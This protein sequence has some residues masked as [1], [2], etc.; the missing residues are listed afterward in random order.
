MGRR[1]NVLQNTGASLILQFVTAISGLI[2]PKLIISAFG[3]EVNGLCASI[4]QFLGYIS[5]LQAG[6]EGV[7]RASLYRPLSNNDIE[8]V[9]GIVNDAKNFYRKIAFVFI[10]YVI[11]LC[12][13][14]PLF[15]ESSFDKVYIS[16]LVLILS[17]GTFLQ[18]Y[19][20]LA[21]ISLINAD[22]KVRVI[23]YVDAITIL[24]NLAS[25]VA[26]IKLGFGIHAVKLCSCFVFTIKPVFYGWYVNKNYQ[27]VKTAKLATDEMRVKWNGL[28]HHIAFFIHSNTDVFLLTI[29]ADTKVVSVYA[30]YYAIVFGVEKLINAIPAGSNAS[31]GNL[32]VTERRELVNA[33]FDKYEFIQGGII[34]VVFS[35]TAILI[36]P[37]MKVYSNG[38]TDV[39]YIQP[40][41]AYILIFAEFLYCYRSIYSSATLNAGKYKETQAG[42]ILECLVNLSVS[43][44]LVSRFSLIGVAI[45]TACGMGTRLIFEVLFLKGNVL[46]RPILLAVKNIGIN[47]GLIMVLVF[48]FMCLINVEIETMMQWFLLAIVVTVYCTVLSALVYLVV[49][50]K[51][52]IYLFDEIK[53]FATH[54]SGK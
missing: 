39:N 24:L 9:S 38:I 2:L 14:Y 21:Y 29:F 37:F 11:G 46:N 31:I 33:V 42:A 35:I 34:T 54:R 36:I 23:Y 20:S 13:L 50:K 7:F 3:S 26:M 17:I 40:T 41:F 12:F 6:V 49:Y 18:Y 28:V 4:T 5:L 53:S 32:L 45:G 16:F 47:I 43:I 30:V 52:M 1:Q 25:T 19:F 48:P 44:A 15:V 22:Q 8:K 27:I 51:N 10:P